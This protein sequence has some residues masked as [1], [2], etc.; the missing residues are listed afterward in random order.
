MVNKEVAWGGSIKMF[1]EGGG[2]NRCDCQKDHKSI[3][4]GQ[5]ETRGR[6][7]DGK[8]IPD[9]FFFFFSGSSFLPSAALSVLVDPPGAIIS[10]PEI[11]LCAE[12]LIMTSPTLTTSVSYTLLSSFLREE[13]RY[14]SFWLRTHVPAR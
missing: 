13:N 7:P 4:K 8:R 5:L 12:R 3:A 1:L 6:S 10:L 14:V 9:S 11:L 2:R